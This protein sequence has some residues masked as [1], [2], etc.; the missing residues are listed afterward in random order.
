MTTDAGMI[1]AS[2]ETDTHVQGFTACDEMLRLI[3]KILAHCFRSLSG[4]RNARCFQLCEAV[5][6]S[7]APTNIASSPPHRARHA[8]S[9]SSA[10]IVRSLWSVDRLCCITQELC[11]LYHDCRQ[12]SV[13]W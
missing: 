10:G 12:Y 5:Q 7:V 9:S 8:H 1:T 13:K 11:G 3:L 2:I 4:A 6:I